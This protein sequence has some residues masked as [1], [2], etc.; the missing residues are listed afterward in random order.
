M[1]KNKENFKLSQ[2]NRYL[3]S[4]APYLISWL[5]LSIASFASFFSVAATIE[6]EGFFLKNV[7]SLSS[8]MYL[9]LKIYQSM[10]SIVFTEIG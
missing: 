3:L 4:F 6:I 10:N 1:Y 9:D 8:S 2:K 7:K 5:S